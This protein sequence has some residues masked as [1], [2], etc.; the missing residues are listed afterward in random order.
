M[1]KEGNRQPD[2]GS[3]MLLFAVFFIFAV[4]SIAI[5]SSIV[6]SSIGLGLKIGLIEETFYIIVISADILIM[7]YSAVRMLNSYRNVM[8]LLAEISTENYGTPASSS[9]ATKPEPA[10]S[11]SEELVVGIIS[12]NGGKMLQNALVLDSGLSPATVTRVLTSLEEKGVVERTRHGMTN[13]V[14]LKNYRARP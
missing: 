1:K 10:L 8:R 14:D 7:T 12:R 13:A 4:V 9:I 2:N 6:I 3:A 5:S 11:R